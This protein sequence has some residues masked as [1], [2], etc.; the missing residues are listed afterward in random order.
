MDFVPS[1]KSAARATKTSVSSGLTSTI[2][3]AIMTGAALI[4]MEIE[5]FAKLLSTLG[6]ASV[7]PLMTEASLAA[8]VGMSSS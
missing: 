5:F 2:S 3:R 8:G 6:I 1:S 4:V 7:Q